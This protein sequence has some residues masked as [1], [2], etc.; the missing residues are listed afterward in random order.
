LS[1]DLKDLT[2][3]AT[4]TQASLF[5][6]VSNDN[7]WEDVERFKRY[8][9]SFPFYPFRTLCP[10]ELASLKLTNKHEFDSSSPII[11]ANTQIN[12]VFSRRDNA[13]L[14]NYMLPFN[15]DMEIGTNATQLTDEQRKLALTFSQ[16][17]PPPADAA[18]GTL[19]TTTNHIINK[20]EIVINDIYLQVKK[21]LNRAE[22]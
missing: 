13:K 4:N 2:K 19:A 15:L 18:A 20:V 10:R 9:L 1:G 12:F 7:P 16:V 8:Q 22:T 5:P 17:I 21:I 11:P 3:V 6:G 14:I